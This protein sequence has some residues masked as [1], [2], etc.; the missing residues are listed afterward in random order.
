MTVSAARRARIVRSSGGHMLSITTGRLAAASFQILSFLSL[1]VRGCVAEAPP[2]DIWTVQAF[3]ARGD[4]REP[5]SLDA[6]QLSSRYDRDADVVWF[7]VALFGAPTVEAF[8]VTIAVDSG[9]A[10]GERMPW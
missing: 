8:R 3:D 5:S 10:D 1:L 7:R 6:A 4:G 9:A 2:P